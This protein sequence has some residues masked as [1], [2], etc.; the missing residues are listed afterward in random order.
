MLN[1]SKNVPSDPPKNLCTS[2]LHCIV[3]SALRVD[4]AALLYLYRIEIRPEIVSLGNCQRIMIEARRKYETELRSIRSNPRVPSLM[5]LHGDVR[6]SKFL[7]QQTSVIS[8]DSFTTLIPAAPSPQYPA[9][10]PP[11]Q[12]TSPSPPHP[13]QHAP[14]RPPVSTRYTPGP[15]TRRSNIHP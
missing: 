9:H 13:R 1:C 15:R 2:Y 7:I 3:P 10:V 11:P 4:Q 14:T 12:P 8:S 5:H 6:P